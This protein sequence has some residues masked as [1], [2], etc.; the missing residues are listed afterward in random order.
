MKNIPIIGKFIAI[1][2]VFGAFSLAVAVYGSSRIMYIDEANSSLLKHE[3]TAALMMARANRALQATRAALG[4]LM[5]ARSGQANMAA[6]AEIEADTAK[7]EDFMTKAMSSVKDN[8]ALAALKGDGLRLVTETCG[9]A[10][11]MATAATESETIVASQNEF[12]KA[13]QPQFDVMAKRFTEETNIV[14]KHADD[15]SRELAAMS[16]SAAQMMLMSVI[17]GVLVVTALGYAAI[18]AWLVLPI[19]RLEGTM[20]VL[21]GGDLSADVDGTDRKDEIGAMA[22]AV[23]V[24]KDE[25]LRA[26]E[27]SR[28]A[29]SAREARE[30]DRLRTA[31]AD[32]ARAEDMAR[33]TEGLAS[34]LT[35]LSSGDLS[36]ELREPFAQEFEG[37]RADFN[38]AVAQLR[39]TLGAVAAATSAI[40][41]GSRELSGSAD[42]LSKRTE[43]QA[44]S[45]E[46]TAAAI[47]EITANVSNSSQRTEE[48]RSMAIAAN[49]SARRSAEVVTNAVNAMQRIEQ[50]SAQISSIISVIDEIAFQTN[51]LALNAG[52]EAARAGE[53]GK[54]F[55]VVA[56]EVRELAQRSAKAAKEIK[57]LIRHSETEVQSGV[58]LVSATG[59]ALQVIEGHVAAINGQLDAIATSAREQS[60]GLSQVNVAVNQMDQVTQQNAAMVEEAN[61]ASSSLATEAER[62][63]HLIGRFQLGE[64]AAMAAAAP[65]ASRATPATPVARAKPAGRRPV[66]VEESSARFA[67]PS[68]A[69]RM[70]SKLTSAFGMQAAPSAKQDDWEEF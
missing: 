45:L 60:V 55:A 48:A 63:R 61:A 51:L 41:S 20:T 27:L 54:G 16:A 12:F 7:F 65:A 28:E 29:E 18:R 53:A 67:A 70:M 43:Q 37:L 26:R 23:Q 50:S 52:V 32:Q 40:D 31:R 59:E 17:A 57:D 13:C 11:A 39:E 33:A 68:P 30:A 9:P 66:A 1:M 3:S 14:V 38:T 46:D 6:K 56:Q 4:D 24:F 15:R 21:A 58:E 35:R 5:M 69:R 47:D 64:G 2:A 19:R 8:R 25:G 34:G 44:A 49:E 36:V 22:K 62:L 42:D 10:I